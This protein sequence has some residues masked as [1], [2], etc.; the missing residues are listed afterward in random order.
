MSTHTHSHTHQHRARSLHPAGFLAGMFLA[1]QL[2]ARHSGD[3][4]LWLLPHTHTLL[5][6]EETELCACS[7]LCFFWMLPQQITAL[8]AKVRRQREDEEIIKRSRGQTFHHFIPAPVD[9]QQGLWSWREANQRGGH[10]YA[11]SIASSSYSSFIS[12]AAVL[13]ALCGGIGARLLYFTVTA[14]VIYV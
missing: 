1:A 4:W 3:I 9:L 10:R 6:T 7:S 13:L 12:S 11:R 2:I 8:H 5:C 14:F